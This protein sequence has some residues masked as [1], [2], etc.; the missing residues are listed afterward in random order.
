[1][2]AAAA[3]GPSAKA[4][5]LR[6]LAQE[7][8][9]AHAQ[10]ES[11]DD[12][13]RD[14]SAMPMTVTT[15]SS[16]L[17]TS[18][19]S[20]QTGY[21]YHGN[22][23]AS[24]FAAAAAASASL[25]YYQPPPRVRS[26]GEF[27]Q[28]VKSWIALS[29]LW[30]F[31]G[32]DDVVQQQHRRKSAASKKRR[33]LVLVNGAWIK[34]RI[35]RAR[36]KSFALPNAKLTDLPL[37]L[38]HQITSYLP[39]KDL[40]SLLQTPSLRLSRVAQT[41]IARRRHEITSLANLHT[42]LAYGGR[43]PL[44]YRT[45]T[46][47][48]F[49][50]HFLRLVPEAKHLLGV[51]YAVVLAWFMVLFY[52]G[53]FLLVIAIYCSLDIATLLTR[54]T[55]SLLLHTSPLVTTHHFPSF[56][57][58]PQSLSYTHTVRDLCFTGTTDPQSPSR[59]LLNPWASHLYLLTSC[60]PRLTRLHLVGCSLAWWFRLARLKSL[61]E[62]VL[63]TCEL[64][65]TGLEILAESCGDV[66]TRLVLMG[67]EVRGGD[68]SDES[69]AAAGGESLA[70]PQQPPH[71]P[72]SPTTSSSAKPLQPTAIFPSL[73]HLDIYH[74]TLIE[75]AGLKL[76]MDRAPLLNSITFSEAC[77]GLS[78]SFLAAW[79]APLDQTSSF[80][81]TNIEELARNWVGAA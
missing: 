45:A 15:A 12:S 67:G 65:E 66:M 11:S 73:T 16:S 61:Q 41:A 6:V 39:P 52:T 59:G 33:L 43:M 56:F 69:I 76:I 30:S 81:I 46:M 78:G 7:P 79:A 13:D 68:V 37:E 71:T 49:G 24:A 2:T 36:R 17:S 1:M 29:R 28:W 55:A 47:V 26:P 74:S 5:K 57:R 51:G 14:S 8:C 60:C 70:S 35:A 38:L 21:S 48:L 58:T 25:R 27:Q 75:P 4:L 72:P 42:F 77:K 44:F 23:P 10:D 50:R 34:R 31:N 19:Y 18:A 54:M 62:L 20:T 9:Y 40:A 53:P 22:V 64:D 3:A 32:V 80:R 63:E